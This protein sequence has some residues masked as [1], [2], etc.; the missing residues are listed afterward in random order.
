MRKTTEPVSL[1]ER[2]DMRLHARRESRETVA[3]LQHGYEPSAGMLVGDLDHDGREFVEV[4]IAERESSQWIAVARVEAS[5]QD[6]QVRPVLIGDGHQPRTE[7]AQH[8]LFS[9]SGRQRAVERRVLARA[10]AGFVRKAGA[11]I[12]G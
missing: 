8:L 5:G 12:P 4:V 11:R 7:R 3:A 9:R 2:S 6:D 1:E 10:I